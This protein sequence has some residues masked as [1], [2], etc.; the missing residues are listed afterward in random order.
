[1]DTNARSSKADKATSEETTLRS[2]SLEPPPSKKAKTT[3]D[4]NLRIANA[5]K[6]VIV[7][8]HNEEFRDRCL[9]ILGVTNGSEAGKKVEALLRKFKDS[10]KAK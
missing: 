6:S 9:T 5:F 2:C 10:K 7:M 1:M 3:V 8:T 4:L